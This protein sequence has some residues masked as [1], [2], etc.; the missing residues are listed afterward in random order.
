M[1]ILALIAN[2]IL[3]PLFTF[4]LLWVFHVPEGVRIGLLLLSIGGGAPFIPKIVAVAKGKV[5]SAI[6]LMLLLLIVTIFFM[7]VAVPRIF[8][9]AS[10]S[11]WDIAKSLLFTMLLPLAVALFVKARFSDIAGRQ[12]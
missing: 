9:G 2:F 7:P 10:E 5:P 3:V 4:G 1:V 11:A 12:M 8:P 6:G